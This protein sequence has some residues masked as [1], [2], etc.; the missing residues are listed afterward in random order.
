M[1]YCLTHCARRWPTLFSSVFCRCIC[2]QRGHRLVLFVNLAKRKWKC[3]ICLP[4]V[5][6]FQNPIPVIIQICDRLPSCKQ[7]VL[8]SQCSRSIG[9]F[10]WFKWSFLDL[11][12]SGAVGFEFRFVDS[13]QKIFQKLAHWWKQ[14]RNWPFVLNCSVNLIRRRAV[15]TDHLCGRAVDWWFANG[16]WDMM[17]CVLSSSFVVF[18]TLPPPPSPPPPAPPSARPPA[19]PLHKNIKTFITRWNHQ[20]YHLSNDLFNMIR[21][22]LLM[23]NEC[24]FWVSSTSSISCLLSFRAR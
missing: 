9:P 17:E 16:L 2:L 14:K 11:L 10:M 15:W 22:Y 20:F 5:P 13:V 1:L 6:H 21:S 23:A 24:C 3:K 19:P 4:C 7:G 18:P 8:S 12:L